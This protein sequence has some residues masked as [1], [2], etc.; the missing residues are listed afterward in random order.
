MS[1]GRLLQ[2]L[3]ALPSRSWGEA[4]ADDLE[5]LFN[6]SKGFSAIHPDFGLGDH[7]AWLGQDA[8]NQLLVEMKQAIV[9]FFPQLGEV[10]LRL[11]HRNER[12]IYTISIAATAT[13]A[14]HLA[15]AMPRWQVQFDPKHHHFIC[16]FVRVQPPW[17][18]A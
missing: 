2:R 16:E 9:R 14:T 7:D 13:D 8:W 15:P 4:T 18:A 17:Q 1:A 10:E 6:A 3:G 12:N 5:R 11:L